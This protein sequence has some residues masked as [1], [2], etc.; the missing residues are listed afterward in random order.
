MDTNL[1]QIIDLLSKRYDPTIALHFSNPWELAVAVI[2]SAQCTDKRVNIVTK[3][4]FPYLAN[5]EYMPNQGKNEL[6]KIGKMTREL[7]QIAT[8]AYMSNTALEQLIHATGFYKAKAHNIQETAKL[9]L[10]KY[11]GRIPD[12]M[13]EL[14]LLPG[15]ARKTAN[16]LLSELYN[17]SEGIVVDTHVKRITQRLHLVSHENAG[18]TI[19]ATY[20]TNKKTHLDYYKNA[21]PEKI[22][23]QL[24]KIIPKEYWKNFSHYIVKLGRDTCTAQ[25]PHCTACTLYDVCPSKRD[26]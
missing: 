18:G 6:Q 8:T 19:Q 9:L 5:T 4:L 25:R 3:T 26:T 15:V 13:Q 1:H 22:E 20:T 21:S 10:A 7:I 17:K 16:V 11:S 12:T 14:V 23:Q 2:L 24:M